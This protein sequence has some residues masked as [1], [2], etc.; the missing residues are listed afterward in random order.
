[1]RLELIS[2]CSGDY[3][4]AQTSN[5]MFLKDF[6]RE[7]A[8]QYET[9]RGFPITSPEGCSYRLLDDR[10]RMSL[11]KITVE[12][13]TEQIEIEQIGYSPRTEEEKRFSRPNQSVESD[14]FL[15]NSRDSI[16]DNIL[17]RFRNYLKKNLNGQA[18]QLLFEFA[19]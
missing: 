3:F 15:L 12:G 2:E 8:L 11:I 5:P 17:Q 9:F 14:S 16:P 10:N 4:L 13:K 6:T 18:G 7:V 19:A 1:M